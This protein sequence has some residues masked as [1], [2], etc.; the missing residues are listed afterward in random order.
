MHQI[1]RP[2]ICA[3]WQRSGLMLAAAGGILSLMLGAALPAMAATINVANN[4]DY[5]FGSGPTNADGLGCTL[6]KALA[7]AMNGNGAFTDCAA[8]SSGADIIA[9]ADAADFTLGTLGVLDFITKDITITAP[10][11]K[12]FVGVSSG[13]GAGEIFHVTG[14]GAKLTMNGFTLQGAANSAV[15]LANGGALAMNVGA[16]TNNTHNGTGGG[17]ITGDGTIALTAIHFTG[18]TAPNGSGGAINLNNSSYGAST[19]TDSFFDNN[20]ANNSGGAIFYSGSGSLV[21]LGTLTITNTLFGFVQANVAS[22]ANGASEGGGAIFASAS[23]LSSQVSLLNNSFLNNKVD[24]TDGRGGAIFN[25]LADTIPMVVDHDL[26]TL[27]QVNGGANSWGAAIYTADSIVVRASSFIANDANGGKGGAIASNAQVADPSAV[28]P[29]L[30]AIVA[31]STIQGNNADTGAGLYSFAQFVTRD[32]Q[33]INVTMDGNTAATAG[34]GIFTEEVGAGTATTTLL[35]TIVSNNTANGAGANCGGIAVTNTVGNLQWPG[36]TCLANAAIIS[37]DPKLNSPFINP[38]DILTLTM[39]LKA[40][41][42]AS[43]SGD[44]ATCAA[45]PVLNLDQ[46]SLV[47]PIR[48]LGGPNCDIGAYESS[49]VPGYGSAPPPGAFI[50][51]ATPEG[52]TGTA[53]VVIFETGS[54]DLT[55]SSY[56][57]VG[58]PQ[59]TIAPPSAPFT[60]PDASGQTK[61]LTLSCLN[62]TPGPFLATLTVN[63]NAPG[64]PATYTIACT[65]SGIPDLVITKAHAGNFVQGQAGTYSI[66]VTN[67]GDAPTDGSLVSVMD[68]LPAGLTATGA[69]GAGWACT[70]PGGPCTR[71]D[72]LAAGSSYPTITLTVNVA[73]NA[74]PSVVN[75]V[76]VAGGGEVNLGNDSA[77]DPTNI[78]PGPDLSIAKT[79]VGNFSQSQV[80][81]TY[82]ITVTNVGGS[83]TDGSLVTVAD[84]LPPGFTATSI[85]GGGWICTPPAGPCTRS[86]V[87]PAGASWPTLTLTGNVANNAAALIT[88]TA[89]VTGGGDVNPGNNSASDPT[90]VTAA[91]PDLAITKTHVGNF[92]QGQVGAT[93]TITVSNIGLLATSGTV[94][95]TDI[96]PAG[97]I[98]TGIAGA[99]WTTCTQPAGPCSRSDALPVGASYPPLTLTVDVANNAAATVTNTAIVSGGGETNLGNDSASDPTTVTAGADLTITKTHAGN[100]TQ[101]QVGATYTITVS[102]IGGSAS[103]GT[104]TVTDALPAGLTATGIVGAGWTCPPPAGPCTRSDAL[105]QA[106]S[107]PPLTLTVNVANNA[108]ASII[109]T[110]TVGGGGDVNPVNNTASDPT[111]VNPAAPDLTIAKT[112]VGNFTQGQF[113]ATY[114]ITVSNGGTLATSGTVTVTDALPAGLTAT[115]IAGAG[116]TTCTQPSGPCSRSDALPVGASYPP[117]TLTVSVANNA[118]AS[119]INTATVSGGGETNLGNDSASDPTTV[120]AG[121]DLTITKT[122]AGNF[123]QGQVGATYTITVSNIGG[124]ASSGAVTVS[125]VLPAGLTATGITGIGWTSCTQPAGPCSRSDALA[126]GASYPALTL[127]VSVAANAAAS[128]INTA[129]VSGGGDVNP[130]NNSASDATTVSPAA[131]DLAIAKTHAG[132]FM[133]GQVGVTYTITVSNIGTLATSGT[134]TVTDLLPAGLTATGIAG[135]GWTTCTQPAG[136][137]SRSDALAAGA[138]YPALTLTVNVAGN[139]PASVINTATVAGGGETNLAND[140]ANDTTTINVAAPDLS[141]TKTHAGI[142]LRGQFGAVY[143]ITV[144]N[145]GTAPTDGTT[146]TVTDVLPPA[147]TASGIVGIG[148]NCTQPAGPCTRSDVLAPGASYPPLAVDVN[149]AINAPPSVVNT[150]TVTGG[151]DTNLANDT[152]NDTAVVNSLGSGPGS[153]I[154][155]LGEYALLLLAVLVALL[156]AGLGMRRPRG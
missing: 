31:N 138:S 92:T 109:N 12:T 73:N 80:G 38:P 18:N 95:V 133:Q 17:A 120:T 98:A 68:A 84:L 20:S 91:A 93:Y 47:V 2:P 75:G 99:G 3:K 121:A 115:G 78:S 122:H 60:I 134:V 147:L 130:A 135:A 41:S 28:P 56:S 40:G 64:T 149:V 74:P 4:T 53:T 137:C 96:L 124:V 27:N 44:N 119:I 1:T 155:T 25:S 8:G 128:I 9:F 23:G 107:Y 36:T 143:T 151:G 154:P 13:I 16:F 153:V 108:A 72:P 90:T 42:A 101:G 57:L 33:L 111:T 152:V 59:I 103:S 34:G 5:A 105:A 114:T 156:G 148:W 67:V 43:N 24:G 83:P 127:T 116:W 6:R 45:F 150:A 126:P 30:G 46:R 94:T 10:G 39:S 48:P 54:D 142:L 141:V 76:T 66:N 129:T 117:L 131:P 32:I 52:V 145:N 58:A 118:P 140:T 14:T 55:I 29:R 65:V 106:A 104:V 63:H 70:P 146:V 62:P 113:G 35:N 132:N 22:A 112:H 19:I 86:D 15:F 61:T 85:V 82:T 51:I 87:L 11:A 88:N 79:H 110:A 123:T 97:L 21:P 26:F 125:D 102:N 37:G 144:T 136:P 69:V 81:A 77:I 50:P 100:F 89:T 139:A 7:N 49:N 71:N